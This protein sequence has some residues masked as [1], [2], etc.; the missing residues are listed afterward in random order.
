MKAWVK[1]LLLWAMLLCLALPALAEAD[2]GRGA[3]GDA[4]V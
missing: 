2:V 3:T 1:A 4:V